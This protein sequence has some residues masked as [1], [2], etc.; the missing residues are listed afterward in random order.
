MNE[1]RGRAFRKGWG[2]WDCIW[3]R[4]RNLLSKL[5]QRAKWRAKWRARKM[6]KGAVSRELTPWHGWIIDSLHPNKEPLILLPHMAVLLAEHLSRHWAS[7][8]GSAA[9]CASGCKGSAA[10]FIGDI[11][12]I[13]HYD[14]KCVKFMRQCVYFNVQCLHLTSHIYFNL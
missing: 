9:A 5:R 1:E 3:F 10:V 12:F 14:V 6:E 7:W 2:W 11:V 13:A 4:V 8:C